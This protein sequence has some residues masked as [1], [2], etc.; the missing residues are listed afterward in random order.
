MSTRTTKVARE[1]LRLRQLANLTPLQ[2]ERKSR[3]KLTAA[4]L[5]LH[6]QSC[7]GT[8]PMADLRE[9]A[10]IYGVP[11]WGLLKAAGYVTDQDALDGY[12]ALRGK[13]RA[14]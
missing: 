14:A 8:P 10:R 5:S 2:V 11:A 6:E 12:E 13:K 9:L 1:L 7:F 4:A 3:G